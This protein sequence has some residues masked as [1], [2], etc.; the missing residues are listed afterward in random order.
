MTRHDHYMHRRTS[1]RSVLTG[2][3]DIGTSHWPR[4]TGRYDDGGDVRPRFRST[5]LCDKIRGTAHTDVIIVY[6]ARVLKKNV[7]TLEEHWQNTQPN[8]CAASLDPTAR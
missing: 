3:H 2:T 6:G 5:R 4:R 7:Q 8:G 1:V